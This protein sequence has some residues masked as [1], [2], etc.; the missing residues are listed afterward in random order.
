M[1]EPTPPARV[2]L[3]G[4]SGRLGTELRGLLPD[5]IAPPRAEM[6]LTEPLSL[7]RALA[8]YQPAL[9][10]HAAAYT[11]VA[12]AEVDRAGCWR[13][14]VDGSRQ[15]V[16]A[17][18]A[19]GL[20]LVHISTDYV[21]YGDRGHYQEDD[22]PG[23]VRNYYALTKLVAESLVRLLP[24]HLVIRTSFRPRAWPYPVAYGDLYTSQDYVDVI[25]PEIALAVARFWAIAARGYS[26]LHIATERKSVWE[27]ARRRSNSVARG[28]R[29]DA[30]KN[31]GVALPEDVS[32]DT[33][34]WQGLKGEWK[35]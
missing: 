20:P 25:A 9:I 33:A 30:E 1:S 14:N 15:L 16:A 12:G 13:V 31:A 32:L 8:T 27:L 24:R 29:L 4:G 26:T 22:P 3:T 34:R 23:P 6:D 5:L 10:V 7:R 11:D 28:S 21:F 19:S 17:A 18:L 35:P 2:L